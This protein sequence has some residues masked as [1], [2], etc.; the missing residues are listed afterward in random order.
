MSNKIL[1]V[2]EGEKT[3]MQICENLQ[4]HF[5]IENS[6]IQCAFCNDV[7]ELYKE[8]QVDEDLDTFVLIKNLPQNIDILAPYTRNDFAEIYMFFDYDGHDPFADDEKVKHLLTFF[9]EETS[10]GKLFISYPMV[11]SLKHIP[12]ESDFKLLKVLCKEKIKYKQRVN[13]ETANELK[14]FTK[15]SNIIWLKLVNLHLC[16]MNWIVFDSYSLPQS[17]ISQISIFLKQEEKYISIDSTVAVLS[18]FPIFLFDYYGERLISQL[19]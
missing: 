4:S 15:Y 16:K 1:F 5:V 13:N 19:Q 6:I 2:F 18:S 12:D 17:T 10:K 3:E 9:D 7:Y 11:E 8:I 14:D